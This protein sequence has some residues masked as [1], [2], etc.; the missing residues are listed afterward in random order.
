[1]FIQIWP[2]L[3]ALEEEKCGMRK[4]ENLCSHSYGHGD[5]LE[6]HPAHHSTHECM[7]QI[8]TQLQ[9]IPLSALKIFDSLSNIEKSEQS[10]GDAQEAG[11]QNDR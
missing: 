6:K 9:P 2:L 1:M 5:H 8:R 11:D 7:G 10:K 4:V 3:G